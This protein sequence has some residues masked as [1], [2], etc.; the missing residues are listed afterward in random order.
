M[1][2]LPLYVTRPP[3]VCTVSRMIFFVFRLYT[4]TTVSGSSAFTSPIS[5][6]KGP[7]AEEMFPQFP[8]EETKVSVMDGWRNR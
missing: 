3:G 5:M 4:R 7:T 1:E 8:A 2:V 6:A